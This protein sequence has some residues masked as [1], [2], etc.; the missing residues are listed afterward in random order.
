MERGARSPCHRAPGMGDQSDSA[1]AIHAAPMSALTPDDA[2]YQG[3]PVLRRPSLYVLWSIRHRDPPLRT[4][5]PDA[6]LDLIV[7]G[8]RVRAAC[9]E[10]LRAEAAF[11]GEPADRGVR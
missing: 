4:V 1:S 7:L 3:D 10:W 11:E 8:P 9:E 5:A 6:R 2:Q